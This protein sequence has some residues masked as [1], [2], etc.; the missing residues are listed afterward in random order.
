MQTLM[1]NIM[2]KTTDTSVTTD[3]MLSVV[4]TKIEGETP[5]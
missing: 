2:G 5:T 3:C 1:G 4:I